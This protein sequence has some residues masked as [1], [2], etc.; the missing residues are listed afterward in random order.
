LLVPLRIRI[1]SIFL[2]LSIATPYFPAQL[3][4]FEHRSEITTV[5]DLNG[6][7]KLDATIVDNTMN[8]LQLLSLPGELLNHIFSYCH[9]NVSVFEND[10]VSWN[11]VL[12]LQHAPSSP[13]PARLVQDRRQFFGLTQTCR[14]LRAEFRPLYMSQTQV[15]IKLQQV[16]DYMA[17]FIPT[18]DLEA[19]QGSHANFVIIVPVAL[20][21]KVDLIPLVK[22]RLHA[23]HVKFFFHGPLSTPHPLLGLSFD[24]DGSKATVRALR[25]CVFPNSIDVHPALFGSRPSSSVEQLSLLVQSIERL[26]LRI[27]TSSRFSSY[28]RELHLT[29]K[30]DVYETWM[31]NSLRTTYELK[32]MM[33]LA[34]WLFL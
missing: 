20:E 34:S 9:E 31:D 29:F 15:C 28:P 16:L 32:V 4:K 13:K 26:E 23:P 14:K 5:L 22:F 7:P 24:P 27:P 30:K 11:D 33:W 10:D 12:Y 17:T 2:P 19:T 21:H 3:H 6:I 18:T 25:T 1:L 8:N